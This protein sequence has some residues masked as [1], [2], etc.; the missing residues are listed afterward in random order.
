MKEARASTPE[1]WKNDFSEG[2]QGL[3]PSNKPPVIIEDD[4]DDDDDEDGPIRY[5][6]CFVTLRRIVTANRVKIKIF[7]FLPL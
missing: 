6:F 7:L 2:K 1:A 5:T 4:E 3:P